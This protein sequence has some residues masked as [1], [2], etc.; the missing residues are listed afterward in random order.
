MA[1][2][3]GQGKGSDIKLEKA[4][5]TA[6]ALAAGKNARSMTGWMKKQGQQNKMSWQRRYFVLDQNCLFYYSSPDLKTVIGM[7]W[8]EGCSVFVHDHSSDGFPLRL[9]TIG[10]REYTL[11][12]ESGEQ[13]SSW[14]TELKNSQFSRVESNLI[15]AKALAD[16]H[17]TRLT[18]E[19][20]ALEIVRDAAQSEVLTLVEKLAA[21]EKA[22]AEERRLK[23]HEFTRLR[24]EAD[25]RQKSE[26]D[27]LQKR[28][29]AEVGSLRSHQETTTAVSQKQILQLQTE[30]SVEAGKLAEQEETAM[31]H[32]EQALIH[33]Q[34]LKEEL[35][36]TTEQV[37]QEGELAAAAMDVLELENF[38]LEQ[39]AS[40]AKVEADMMRRARGLHRR[41]PTGSGASGVVVGGEGTGMLK[42]ADNHAADKPLRLWVGT[43]NVGA[44]EP[45]EA[46]API[47]TRIL[48]QSLVVDDPCDVYFLGLQE[49][50]S[51]SVFNAFE[52]LS[53][54]LASCERLPLSGDAGGSSTSAGGAGG[55]G[56]ASEEHKDR[57]KIHGRGDGSLMS[58]KFT[59]IACYVRKALMKDVRVLA[60][61]THHLE[62]LGSKG[63][64]AV[65]LDIAGSTIVLA[66][67]HL[68]AMKRD[69]RRIQYRELMANLGA[70]LGER[71]FDLTSQFHHVIW[72]GDLNYR[73][74]ERTGE[75]MPAEKA[76]ALLRSGNNGA[77][78]EDHDELTQERRAFEAFSPFSEPVPQP[79]FYPTY[80][81]V[82][83]REV[84]DYTSDW[85]S[86]VY[87]TRY[88]EQIYKGGK[89]KERT[90]GYC[91]RI[92]FCSLPDAAARLVPERKT[93]LYDL[94]T[95]SGE[96]AFANEA[97]NYCAV[98][99][100][101]GMSVSDHSPVYGV[102]LLRPALSSGALRLTRK[103]NMTVV[104][105]L[106]AQSLLDAPEV[107]LEILEFHVRGG[108]V[109]PE[110][111]RL[112]V[113]FPAPF[114]VKDGATFVHIGNQANGWSEEATKSKSDCRR[115]AITDHVFGTSGSMPV[116]RI[117]WNSSEA[118]RPVS[119]ANLHLLIRASGG[120]FTHIGHNHTTR[121][122]MRD[123]FS[124]CCVLCLSDLQAKDDAT[125]IR[126]H[127]TGEETEIILRFSGVELSCEGRPL[128]YPPD[129]QV[130]LTVDLNL[131]VTRPRK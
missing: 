123:T 118:A 12:C 10:E 85:V 58:T 57:D 16:Q 36:L 40:V 82:E 45:F 89:V 49:G 72:T 125:Y 59:G 25:D 90:P 117:R 15:E 79:D 78:F 6:A 87:R 91:D 32:Q 37:R 46:N 38:K 51:E 61:V 73:C 98:N 41:H 111:T 108:K 71:G 113:M 21:L 33:T 106:T 48:R 86:Q 29:E 76:C 31:R 19:T 60:C 63:G 22:V 95:S 67:C 116:L 47:G 130:P 8:V 18:I 52:A 128:F 121:D 53:S 20:S 102:F 93:L 69:T 14:V 66:T 11:I 28:F 3:F 26:V 62:K 43:W 55:G 7:I 107:G 112:D 50:I 109:T 131:R 114:E 104:A 56:S 120:I 94:V 17:D 64:V 115:A 68:E 24:Q 92:L 81:K 27:S 4:D 44:S 75:P 23:D 100:G 110:A 13:R 103:R 101:P 30:L 96:G 74:V 129:S 99:D 97:D 5:F 84:T 65:A 9:V 127:D 34:K 122:D 2:Y 70:A 1:A 124:G 42:E 77:L 83:N 119:I 126:D 80:K 39:E 105:P 54:I 88:K 35:V